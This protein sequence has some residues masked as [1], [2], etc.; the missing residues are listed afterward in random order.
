MKT[1]AHEKTLPR[2]EKLCDNRKLVVAINGRSDSSIITNIKFGKNLLTDTM[3][4]F[5]LQCR[6]RKNS[7]LRLF[8]SPNCK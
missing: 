5:K 1:L 8:L 6:N 2:H 4:K 7:T 3:S